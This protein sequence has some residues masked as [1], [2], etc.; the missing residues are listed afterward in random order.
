MA[1]TR[2]CYA[3]RERVRRA[4]DVQQATRSDTVI[5]RKL[6]LGSGAVDRLC[7]RKFY[8]LL[9]TYN[10]DWPNYQYAYPWRIWLDQKE[11]AGDP[12]NAPG[13]KLVTGSFLPSPIQITPGQYLLEP[14]DGPPYTEVQL[15]RDTNAAF[16]YNTTPQWDFQMT[17]YFGYWL[18]T[19]VAAFLA[20]AITS[21][22]QTTI[23]MSPN[24]TIDVGSTLVI[25]SERMLVTNN[26]Y[27]STGITFISGCTN[28]SAADNTMTVP[29]GTQF[30][31]QEVIL[32]DSE[33]MLILGI[34]G[35]NLIVKRAYS[36]S[37]LATHS[38][39]LIYAKRQLTVSRAFLGTAAA[40]SY[41]QNTSVSV[42]IYP[43]LVSELT[44]AE[45][46]VSLIQEPQG[47]ANQQQ[48][49]YYGQSQRGQGQQRES[50]PGPGLPDLR[51]QTFEAYGRKARSR[52]VLWR[53]L[54]SV[55]TSTSK[56]GVRSL[57]AAGWASWLGTSRRFWTSCP[58]CP[59]TESRSTCRRSTCT[60]V[61]T[62]AIRFT[63]RYRQMPGTWSLPFT[64]AGRRR[65]PRSCSMA[66]I[67]RSS[68]APG[69]RAS[70]RATSTSGQGASG[71][72]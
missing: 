63:T 68:M 13:G 10:W 27:V 6:Q 12:A 40:T 11:L 9:T 53:S 42:D 51:G 62:A 7:M 17:G 61:T 59:S 52:V 30:A 66:A 69:S 3:T 46:V 31:E 19:Q 22:T 26:Q 15:R 50:F 32:V 4:L 18:Q 67:R 35:N 36:G 55:S 71:A 65:T 38:P 47:Y 64:L 24:S 2:A 37:V 48:S 45:A 20:Q 14:Q 29:D 16:G 44:I 28:A 23:Q 33:W 72:A 8:P 49:N 56:P 34:I 57:M 5:D 41:P 39:V 25:G 60:L 58:M 54:S 21:A 70:L 43:E 1:I